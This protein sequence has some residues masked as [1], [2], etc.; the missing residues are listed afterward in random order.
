MSPGAVALGGLAI[1]AIGNGFGRFG[2]PPLIPAVIGEGVLTPGQ[3]NFA[4]ASNFLGYCLGALAAVPL[5]QRM[6]VRW[7][8]IVAS[9]AS[10]LSFPACALPG[11][12]PVAIS[13]WRLVSG[14]SGS[15]IMIL[16]PGLIFSAVSVERRGR[17][18][19]FSFA[20]IG[21]GMVLSGVALP[22]IAEIGSTL[23]AWL[24]LGAFTLIATLVAMPRLNDIGKLAP[25][26]AASERPRWN[27]RLFGL[28]VSYSGFGVGVV[29]PVVFLSDYIAR[30]LGRGL[31]SGGHAMIAMGIGS[32][33]GPILWGRFADRVGFAI[34][35]RAAMFVFA[36]VV[37]LP[38]LSTAQPVLLICAL[39]VGAS[40]APIGVL[41]SGRAAEL[42]GLG[43]HAR[44]WGVLTILF[45]A[46]Q[47][48]GGYVFAG[49]FS[50]TNSYA[51]MFAMSAAV[52]LVT[53]LFEI[54]AARR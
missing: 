31:A 24:A 33:A 35:L 20:G 50:L 36:A 6:N 26:P 28:A 19:G 51:L 10:V 22:P 12:G 25:R 34:A 11:A 46:M 13:F 40:L 47:A 9:F 32:A 3:A 44:V 41:G 49:L 43:H 38:L 30:E 15:L 42:V 5:G 52:L 1:F 53:N 27:G 2:Y 29:A 8:L 17:T 39:G 37:A 48:G 14:V 54:L 45:A 23:W 7:L 18:M 16:A 21:V 4:A